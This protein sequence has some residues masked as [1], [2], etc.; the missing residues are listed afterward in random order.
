MS[1]TFT[2]IASLLLASAL[3]FVPS[4]AKADGF[5]SFAPASQFVEL[6][7][8]ILAGGTGIT[9]NYQKSFPQ[10]RELDASM[11]AGYGVGAGAVFG[12]SSFL[13]LGTQL[14]LTT[15]HNKLNI[16]VS[17]DD[18]TSVSNIFISNRYLY[19]NIP[20]YLSFRFNLLGSLRWN[21]DAGFY[22]SYGLTGKQKQTIYNSTVNDL[23]QLVPRVVE[24][25]PD[26]FHSE[27]TFINAFYRSDIGLHLG[28]G[29]QFGR[30]ITLGC[31]FQ[32][33]FKNVAYTSGLINPNIH[34]LNIM[35]MLAYKF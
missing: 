11:G 13:G 16:A 15:C 32:V 5:I 28:T 2:R 34:N 1:T 19:A 8:H 3:F 9:Q 20:V 22:Y 21:V 31:Q 4:R 27:A 33:G 14:N 23:G 35:A 17:N 6:D 7:L 10:I 18:V 24:T 25:K 29:L 30:H 26:Y 12:F